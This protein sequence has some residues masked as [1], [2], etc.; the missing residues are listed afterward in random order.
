MSSEKRMVRHIVLV[1]FRDDAPEEMRRE[2]I[3]LSQWGRHADYVSGYVCGH[4][5]QPNPYAG[6]GDEWDWGMSLDMPEDAVERYRDDP[7]H[8]AIPAEVIACAEK[9][10]ILDFVMQ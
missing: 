5:V 2:L 1:K 6:N 3:K 7:T 9:F 8:A 10:A 4:G